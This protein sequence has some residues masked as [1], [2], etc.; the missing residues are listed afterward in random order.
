MR[1]KKI[2]GRILLKILGHERFI[3]FKGLWNFKKI[4]NKEEDDFLYFLGL[5]EE[6][7]N[8]L[9][10]GANVGIMTTLISRKCFKGTTYAFEP[11]PVIFKA[12]LKIVQKKKLSNVVTFNLAV[13]DEDKI[14]KMNMPIFDNLI[15][16]TSSYIMQDHYYF[17]NPNV[18]EFEVNQIRIDSLPDLKDTKIDAIKIDVENYEYHAFLGARNLLLE[19]RPLIFSEM[20][21]GSENQQMVFDL[22][23]NMEYTI[24][25]YDG[26]KLVNFD[27]KKHEKLNYFFIPKEKASIF[28]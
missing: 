28:I 14:N 23:T 21:Y 13:G 20:W 26:K 12:L 6:T 17:N 10:I 7:Y 22:M 4:T 5:L 18:I 19:Q 2:A 1:I 3:Y 11:V 16:D 24:M 9:D 8:V 25:I 15:S 27:S